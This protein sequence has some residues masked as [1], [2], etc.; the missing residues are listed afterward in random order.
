[1]G[2]S[3]ALV[4]LRGGDHILAA[5]ALMAVCWAAATLIHALGAS[6]IVDDL[7][8]SSYT[9]GDGERVLGIR[10]VSDLS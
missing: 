5:V 9:A 4:A 7:E 10:R 2:C 3:F 6:K 1:M 8:Y